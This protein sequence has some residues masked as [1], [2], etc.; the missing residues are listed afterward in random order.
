VEGKNMITVR[1]T[2]RGQNAGLFGA[3]PAGRGNQ[4]MDYLLSEIV[5]GPSGGRATGRTRQVPARDARLLLDGRG[6]REGESPAAARR[7]AGGD[8][9]PEGVARQRLVDELHEAVDATEDDAGEHER[10]NSA[11]RQLMEHDGYEME[12]YSRAGVGGGGGKMESRGRRRLS[13][14]ALREWAQSLLA[15]SCPGRS[16][17]S[18]RGLLER[19]WGG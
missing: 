4:E 2:E 17:A 14:A 3:G 11:H 18:A 10:V 8:D 12:T 19:R 7:S 13:G 1:L 6:V 15:D 5:V 16:R 9:T